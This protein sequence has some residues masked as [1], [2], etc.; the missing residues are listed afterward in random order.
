MIK[1]SRLGTILFTACGAGGLWYLAVTENNLWSQVA[2]LLLALGYS[3]IT[4][5]GVGVLVYIHNDEQEE[6]REFD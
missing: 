6:I 2:C 1:A 3:L 5:F 4:I